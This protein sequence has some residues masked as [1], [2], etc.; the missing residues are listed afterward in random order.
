[1]KEVLVT[2]VVRS[3]INGF[4]ALVTDLN[5]V[6]RQGMVARQLLSFFLEDFDLI[7]END[8]TYMLECRFSLFL[9][10]YHTFICGCLFFCCSCLYSYCSCL[11]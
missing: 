11:L 4:L 9:R 1:M 3:F 10:D 6:H 5:Y 2:V 7:N 8:Y